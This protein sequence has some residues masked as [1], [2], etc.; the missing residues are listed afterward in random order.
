MMFQFFLVEKAQ[1]VPALPSESP[2][3]QKLRII[4]SSHPF[5]F[6][7]EVAQ[8]VP[9]LPSPPASEPSLRR[10]ICSARSFLKLFIPPP[11]PFLSPCS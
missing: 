7:S 3:L 11:C 2:P 4:F 1:A 6:P 9:A 8:A 10:G 5:S